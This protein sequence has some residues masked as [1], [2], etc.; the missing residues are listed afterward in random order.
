MALAIHLRKK[1][2]KHKTKMQD[3]HLSVKNP[4]ILPGLFKNK[5]EKTPYF[6]RN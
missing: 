4:L 3:K 5:S 1:K 6:S 2:Q